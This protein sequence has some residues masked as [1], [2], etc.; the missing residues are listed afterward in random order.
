M[1]WTAGSPPAGNLRGK[2]VSFVE[3]GFA[4]ALAGEATA[5]GADERCES[6]EM[7]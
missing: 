5:S 6:V 3:A 1:N 4:G 2:G 7:G